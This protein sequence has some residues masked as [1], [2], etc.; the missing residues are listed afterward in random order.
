[1]FEKDDNLMSGKGE[2]NESEHPRDSDGKF[3]SKG[4]GTQSSNSQVKQG[5][6]ASKKDQEEN[7]GTQKQRIDISKEKL[8]QL[9]NDI[10]SY[11]PIKL[12]MKDKTIT[13]QFDKYSASKNVYGRWNSN[14]EGY[15][16]KLSNI[17]NLPQY[18]ETSTYSHS[19]PESGKTSRQHKGVK[20]WH[21]FINKVQTN[22]ATYNITVNVRDK[23]SNQY[24]YE[25]AVNKQKSSRPD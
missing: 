5:L 7:P 3:T 14:H 10:L 1:M 24:I 6:S 18:I 17:H 20:E 8:K 4:G 9:V 23:G 22:D 13:A 21:Y 19:K 12:K 2:W 25:V 11:K 15:L 16:F